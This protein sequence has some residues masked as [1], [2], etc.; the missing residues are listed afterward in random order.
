LARDVN[1]QRKNVDWSVVFAIAARAGPRELVRALTT[2]ME[3]EF[4]AF[5]EKYNALFARLRA[6]YDADLVQLRAEYEQRYVA[7]R[8]ELLT[9]IDDEVTALRRELAAANAE[10]DRLRAR[11]PTH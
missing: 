10:L 8:H 9:M 1:E 4:A 7:L 5:T 2:A 6:D 3:T 11:E